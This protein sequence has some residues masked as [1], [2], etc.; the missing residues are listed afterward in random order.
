MFN[1][2][3]KCF[4]YNAASSKQCRHIDK[5]YDNDISSG[6]EKESRG[7]NHPCSKVFQTIFYFGCM[8]DW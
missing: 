5:N 8:A 2:G 1:N 7:F 4:K 3:Y 6:E